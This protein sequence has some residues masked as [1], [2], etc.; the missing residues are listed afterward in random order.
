MEWNRSTFGNIFHRKK[1]YSA[2]TEGIIKIL[3][4]GPDKRLEKLESKLIQEYN[5]KALWYQKS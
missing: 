1:R 3:T 5:K 2:R 4:K